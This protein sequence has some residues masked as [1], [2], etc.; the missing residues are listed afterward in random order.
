MYRAQWFWP[1][2]VA[3]RLAPASVRASNQR[4]QTSHPVR[5]TLVS[6][7]HVMEALPSNTLLGPT[8]P[9]YVAPFTISLSNPLSVLK[10]VA[11]KCL[12]TARLVGVIVHDWTLP[13]SEG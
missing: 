8:V 6:E 5:V 11:L 3:Y 7:D 10:A 2:P 12:P 9:S 13:Y 1:S 4:A